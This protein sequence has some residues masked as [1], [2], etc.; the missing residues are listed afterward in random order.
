MEQGEA[1]GRAQRT[2]V[3]DFRVFVVKMTGRP[4]TRTEQEQCADQRNYSY[5]DCECH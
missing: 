5:Q 3:P 2:V 4:Y 1:L